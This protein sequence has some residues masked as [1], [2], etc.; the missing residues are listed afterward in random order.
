M[1]VARR[2]VGT[3]AKTAPEIIVVLIKA[4]VILALIG[5]YVYATKVGCKIT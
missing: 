5:F 3:R 4:P 1:V 2:L